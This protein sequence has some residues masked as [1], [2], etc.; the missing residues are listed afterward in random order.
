MLFM[1]LALV[2]KKRKEN[3][4]RKLPDK[5]QRKRTSDILKDITNIDFSLATEDQE[6]PA[7][8]VFPDTDFGAIIDDTAE[9]EFDCSSV[10]TTDSENESDVDLNTEKSKAATKGDNK[11]G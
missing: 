4:N 8:T 1:P 9:L 10:D 2:Q 11:D 5:R 6:S 7:S 3:Q